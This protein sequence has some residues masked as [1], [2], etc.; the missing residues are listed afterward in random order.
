M[1]NT[2]KK[3][4]GPMSPGNIEDLSALDRFLSGDSKGFDF[5]YRK[6]YPFMRHYV[7]GKVHNNRLVEDMVHD[8]MMRVHRNIGTYER[9]CTFSSWVWRIVK[10]YLVDHYRKAPKTALNTSVNLSISN[11]DLDP[12]AARE[13]GVVFENTMAGNLSGADHRLLGNER[14]R[15]VQDLLKCVS[16]NERKVM[17]KYFFEGKSY[18]EIA[19]EMDVPVGTMKGWL[20]RAKEKM[21][22]KLGGIEAIESLV[23]G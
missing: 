9:K 11:E 3:A 4:R 22:K 2:E 13:Q 21:R 10:N 18:D 19:L 14:K 17:V 12:D 16:E 8:I 1:E 20:H 23:S 7:Y 5:I 6:Y 15:F